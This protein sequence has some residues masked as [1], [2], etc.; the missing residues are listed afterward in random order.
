MKQHAE[1]VP[2]QPAVIAALLSKQNSPILLKLKREV[3]KMT[4]SHLVDKQRTGLEARAQ[5][6]RRKGRTSVAELT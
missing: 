1:K 2:P 3:N 5:W 6:K 4:R